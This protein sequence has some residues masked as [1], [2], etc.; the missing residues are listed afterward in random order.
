MLPAYRPCHNP[1]CQITP[2]QKELLNLM[3][4]NPG[5]TNY[6]LARQMRVS[7]R[8]VKRHLSDIYRT[9]GAQNRGE[10]LVMVLRQKDATN[11]ES[12]SGMI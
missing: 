1:L 8:T 4:I 7:E 5:A 3:T 10:C 12:G 11:S 2:R 6:D 9:L